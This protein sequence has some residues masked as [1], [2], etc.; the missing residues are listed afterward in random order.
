M[1]YVGSKLPSLRFG[2]TENCLINPRL[3]VAESGADVA[4]HRMSYWPSYSEIPP[5]CRRAYL[6]WLA[7]G[8]QDPEFSIGYVFL[9]FYGLERRLF[10]EGAWHEADAIASEV[11]RL[12]S[13]YGDNNSFNLYAGNLLEKI[14]LRSADLRTRPALSLG[15]RSGYEIPARVRIYLGH[16]LADNQPL[17]A[18]DALLWTLSLPDT[19]PRTPVKRCFDELVALWKIR[20]DQKH[21]KGLKIKPP[22]KR[23]KLT[24]RSASATFDGVVD[25]RDTKEDLPDIAEVTAPVQSLKDLLEACTAELDPYSRLLGRRPN[26]RGTLEAALALPEVLQSGQ[27]APFMMI[28]DWIEELLNDSSLAAV[29]VPKLFAVLGIAM[30][31]GNRLTAGICYQVGTVLDRMNVAFEPDR[32]Y[33]SPALNADGHVVLFRSSGGAPVDPEKPTYVSARA[34]VDVTVLAASADG[35]VAAEE[36]ETLK[37]SLCAVPDLS[38]MERVRLL[39]YAAVMMRDGLRQQ[40]VLNKLKTV[41]KRE[42]QRIAQ[43]AIEAVLADGHASASEVRFLEKLY[44]VLG[45]ANDDLY[46]A[47]HRNAV[48]VDEPVTVAPEEV[49]KGVPIPPSAPI[50]RGGI[51]IDIDRLRRIQ[52]E[53]SAV[54]ALLADI[55]VE[56]EASPPPPPATHA[57]SAFKGLDAAHA[58]LLSAVL[59]AGGS[60]A[61]NEFEEHARSLRLLSDG[62]IETINDWGF[63][64]FDEPILEDDDPISV[65]DHLRAELE[66]LETGA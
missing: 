42:R 55:F 66:K 5:T 64:T 31:T 27:D 50:P 58:E 24:Y 6:K 20:F 19:Y 30:P 59:F 52:S 21:A 35:N 65:A 8:R 41:P 49:A 2:G 26:A 46:G 48:A 40:A 16:R 36:Y 62:A 1:L 37:A 53:T 33:G 18:E 61:R 54:S 45:F 29:T 11:R 43:A 14:E 32:R 56:E 4:G 15:V 23:L 51:K 38:D 12:H 63:E 60:L 7:G 28:R 3:K 10:V 13:V 22:R 39:A 17:D 44:R 25:L 47:L 9:F 34:I 57:P